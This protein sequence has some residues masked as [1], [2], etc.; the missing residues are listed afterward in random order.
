MIPDLLL[1]IA[2]L[3]FVMADANQAFKLYHKKYDDYS[4]ISQWHYRIKIISLIFIIS[5]Y[6]L[7]E[8]PFALTVAILQI[9]LNIYII[10]HID[11]KLINKL[12]NS[13]IYLI[14]KNKVSQ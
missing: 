14:I 10:Y 5:A 1:S 11:N 7:L 12:K 4:A 2:S 6:A 9:L 13:S 3:G 8:L